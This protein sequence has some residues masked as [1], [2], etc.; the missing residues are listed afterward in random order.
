MQTYILPSATAP[1]PLWFMEGKSFFSEK[2]R[3]R[4]FS[5]VTA[6]QK[7]GILVM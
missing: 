3:R 5:H 6:Q 4:T 2:L 7:I 1:S